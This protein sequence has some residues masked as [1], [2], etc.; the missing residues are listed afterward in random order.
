M[1]YIQEQAYQEAHLPEI[2]VRKL[3]NNLENWE[4][5]FWQFIFDWFNPNIQDIKV[6][7]SGS[8]G[9]PKRVMHTKERMRIS[10]QN[11]LNHLELKAGHTALLCMDTKYIGAKMMIV[12]ALE[13]QMH[14]V[15]TEPSVRPL[16]RVEQYVDF[17]AMVPLQVQAMMNSDAKQFSKI[18][19]LIIGGGAVSPKLLLDLQ[20]IPTICYATFGMTET[21]SHIALQQLNGKLKQNSYKALSGV[22]LSITKSGTLVID[23]P[24][25]VEEPIFTNDIV[26][27]INNQSF[28]WLGRSDNVINSGGVKL[29][30]EVIEAKIASLIDKPFFVVG[31]KDVSLGK[32]LVLMIESIPWTKN[33][34]ENL[35]SELKVCLNKYEVPKYIFFVDGF[36]RTETGKIKRTD[37]LKRNTLS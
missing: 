11:T 2:A 14:L 33:K 16:D 9:S 29:Y 3:K 10:A 8:T 6:Q 37:I 4:R 26:R 36:E 30:P 13:A 22:H 1:F 5:N 25:L 17:A 27:L 24:H 35:Q 15:V 19:Q 31:E 32:R 34:V 12:R 7:T 28:E 21:I 18:H 20:T 23:A